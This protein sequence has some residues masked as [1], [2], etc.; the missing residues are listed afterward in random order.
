[1]TW[2]RRPWHL[3]DDGRGTRPGERGNAYPFHRSLPIAPRRYSCLARSRSS[4][5]WILPVDVLGSGPN[6]TLAGALKWASRSRHQA[7]MPASSA[8]APGF[9][10]T[11]AQGRSPIALVGHRDHRRLHHRRVAVERLLD[12]ERGDV[13][14]AGDDDVLGAVLD[15]GIA[16][17][18]AHGEVAGVVP[19]AAERL[20]GGGR[21]SSR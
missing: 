6:T 21:D 11:K 14:A 13:L 15:L 4:N 9:S 18:V 5:F 19:V 16:V 17:G 1:M 12:L 7:M 2:H 8:V 10:V 3:V 20:G